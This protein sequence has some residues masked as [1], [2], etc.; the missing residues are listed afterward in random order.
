MSVVEGGKEGLVQGCWED[1]GASSRAS[2]WTRAVATPLRAGVEPYLEKGF[3]LSNRGL[4]RTGLTAFDAPRDWKVVVN[5]KLGDAEAHRRHTFM[6]S[7]TMLFGR[8]ESFL[9][10]REKDG[11]LFGAAKGGERG[12][13]GWGAGVV[14]SSKSEGSSSPKTTVVGRKSVAITIR[15]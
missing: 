15:C 4:S 3:A 12:E 13:R 14:G 2:A 5:K 7:S 11:T 9:P 1:G 10:L 8:G 6:R